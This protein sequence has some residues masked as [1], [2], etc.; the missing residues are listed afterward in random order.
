M[1]FELVWPTLSTLL[2]ITASVQRLEFESRLG[3]AQLLFP[4]FGQRGV[5]LTAV[6]RLE[7]LPKVE[8]DRLLG[9]VTYIGLG[10]LDLIKL[11]SDICS[12]RQLRGLK[13]WPQGGETCTFSL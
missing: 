5:V 1:G 9:T 2:F 3:S 4:L 10:G 12:C 7:T 11:D 13:P 6:A 8:T